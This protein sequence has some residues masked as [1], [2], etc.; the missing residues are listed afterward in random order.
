MAFTAVCSVCGCLKSG[1]LWTNTTVSSAEK[2][3]KLP[4]AEEL[5]AVV[6][7]ACAGK[8]KEEGEENLPVEYYMM[9]IKEMSM[10]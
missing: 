1:N 4:S 7:P 8:S 5:P 2:I 3:G 9:Q 10:N 6:C